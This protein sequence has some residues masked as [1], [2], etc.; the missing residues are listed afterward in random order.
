MIRDLAERHTKVAA[1]ERIKAAGRLI[2][3]QHAGPMQHR[4]GKHHALG[5][6]ARKLAAPLVALTFQR[7]LFKALGDAITTLRS[8]AHAIGGGVKIKKLPHLQIGWHW[9]KIRHV[10]HH[11]PR[12]FDVI[13][14]INSIEQDLAISRLHQRREHTKSAG[15]S[16]T[17]WPHQTKHLAYRN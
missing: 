11:A 3:D 17:I 2:E 6:T 7:D 9:R 5:L 4:L 8:I 14:D 12:T 13:R 16:R 10:A 15:F 1:R